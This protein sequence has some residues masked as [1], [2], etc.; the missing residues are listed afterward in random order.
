MQKK[1][2]VESL[3]V[4]MHV[5]LKGNWFSHPFKK[6]DFLITDRKQIRKIKEYFS[7]V[8]VDYSKSRLKQKANTV[9]Q[10]LESGATQSVDKKSAS[11]ACDWNQKN[12][13][14]QALSSIIDSNLPAKDKSQAI[15]T[16]SVELMDQ[17]LSAEP[18]EE[19][20]KTFSNPIKELAELVVSE[21]DVTR[22]LLNITSHDYYTYTHCV[23]VGLKAMILAKAMV[24]TNDASLMKEL[25]VGFF[26]H[27]IG[28]SQVD[29]GILNKPGKLTPEEFHIMQQHPARG[30]EI[31]RNA[32]S[33][34]EE[35]HLI[36]LQHHEKNDGTG[37]PYGLKGKQIHLFSRIC[38]FADIYDALTAERSY[39]K[40]MS[41]FE[42]LY[43]MKNRMQNHFD[44]DFMDTAIKVFSGR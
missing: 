28:K 43:L 38:A 15:F 10:K 32:N 22:Y 4:G 25:S 1:V 7:T 23:N 6:S 34:T 33:L 37:Y 21:E 13:P 20:I 31:L 36:T 27:D 17:L 3:E 42:A 39:K 11:D 2:A 35:G 12:R 30:V 19:A 14:A 8:H 18:T 5:Y 41:P 26:L 9:A 16:H 29:P 44:D 24:G 40:G